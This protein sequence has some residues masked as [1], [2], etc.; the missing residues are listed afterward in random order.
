[1]IRTLTALAAL[2]ILAGCASADERGRIW[3]E[4]AVASCD[5]YGFERETDA[6]SEC[7]QRELHA[8]VAGFQAREEGARNRMA[9]PTR[10]RTTCTAGA[11]TVFCY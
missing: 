10:L 6:Y 5:A 11:G 3:A 9:T 8:R 7:L 1:M 4:Q 2:S